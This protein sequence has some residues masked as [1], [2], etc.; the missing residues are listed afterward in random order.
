MVFPS[1]NEAI[2]YG[3]EALF[4]RELADLVSRF[5]AASAAIDSARAALRG[6]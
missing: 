4:A 3:D 1:V 5:D 6:R 2:R